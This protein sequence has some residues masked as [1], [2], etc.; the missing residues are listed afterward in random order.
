MTYKEITVSSNNV[1]VG[2]TAGRRIRALLL[3]AGIDVASAVLFDAVTQVAPTVATL[4]V[5]ANDSKPMFFPGDQGLELN[6]GFSVTLSGTSPKLY[7]YY[8]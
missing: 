4:K 3:M 2:V 7:V 1:F 5:P 8:D 6:K